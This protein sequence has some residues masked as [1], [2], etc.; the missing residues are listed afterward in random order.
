VRKAAELRRIQE[1]YEWLGA[2]GSG[3]VTREEFERLKGYVLGL[4][5]ERYERPTR[6]MRYFTRP[7]FSVVSH[8]FVEDEESTAYRARLDQ[9]A[10]LLP[11]PLLTYAREVS[12]HDGRLQRFDVDETARTI[13]IEVEVSQPNPPEDLDWEHGGLVAETEDTMVTVS[14]RYGSAE[15]V[16]GIT[17]ELLNAVNAPYTEIISEEVDVVE[18]GGFEHRLLLSPEG[19]LAIRFS[20]F[21]FTREETGGPGEG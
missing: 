2:A 13:H 7:E 3:D 17:D 5:F 16:D 9:I 21:S 10:D 15:V 12:L 8:D 14:L 6:Y 19:D 11:P 20:K 4:A 18:G 1:M